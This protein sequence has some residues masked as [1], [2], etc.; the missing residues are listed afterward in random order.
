M[1][2]KS[3]VYETPCRR[4]WSTAGLAKSFDEFQMVETEQ[5]QQYGVEIVD[6]HG[7]RDRRA[8]EFVWRSWTQRLGNS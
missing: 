6:V 7:M 2:F 5:I 3:T 8:I 4:R 1:V